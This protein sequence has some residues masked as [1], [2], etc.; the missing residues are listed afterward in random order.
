[1]R[2]VFGTLEIYTGS[3]GDTLI[4]VISDVRMDN[5]EINRDGNVVTI[6]NGKEVNESFS[7][8]IVFRTINT[9]FDAGSGSSAGN[10][11]LNDAVVSTD[12]TDPTPC[13]V[14]FKGRS[15]SNDVATGPISLN[16]QESYENNRLG[17][18]L[19]GTYE[20]V[21]HDDTVVS[22]GPDAIGKGTIPF[23]IE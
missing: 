9:T 3:I 11:I 22:L 10:S 12:G 13:Y 1:M 2:L 8:E 6:D 21:Q 15:N 5:I 23:T 18:T 14:R 4:G 17:I 20:G 7:E 19:R 16:G